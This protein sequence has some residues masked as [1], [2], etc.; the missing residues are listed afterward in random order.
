MKSPFLVSCVCFCFMIIE[1]IK[2]YI[3]GS[4]SILADTAH[5]F[6]DTVGFMIN[7]FSIYIS[8]NKINLPHNMGYHRAKVLG[9]LIS[10]ILIWTLLIMLNYEATYRI[11][12]S[13]K[14][15]QLNETRICFL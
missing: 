7:F 4:I 12:N 1:A 10:V 5:M 15:N 9:A 6:S 13:V 14:G 11:I 8:R 2:G 3:S